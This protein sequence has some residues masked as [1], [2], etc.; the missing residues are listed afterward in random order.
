MTILS[1]SVSYKLQKAESTEHKTM[2][3]RNLEPMNDVL[4][5]RNLEPKTMYCTVGI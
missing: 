4:Y 5:C 2:Y 3:C 1:L